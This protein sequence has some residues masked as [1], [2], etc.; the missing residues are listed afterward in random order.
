MQSSILGQKCVLTLGV[1]LPLVACEP[2]TNEYPTPDWN[3]VEPQFSEVDPSQ[4]SQTDVPQWPAPEASG[5]EEVT[6]AITVVA[7]TFD[8]GMKRYVGA[9]SL[10]TDS[11]DEHQAPIFDLY[12]GAILENVIIGSPAADGVH[13][14]G[15][16][17]LRNVWWEDV[18]EDAA[19]FRGQTDD[20]VLLI[21]GGGARLAD[22]KVF[23]HNGRGTF[24]L[25][26][27]HVESF[28]KVYRSC[29][30]CEEQV[31]RRVVIENI[32]AVTWDDSSAI[33]GINENYG[34]VAEFRGENFIFDAFDTTI[35]QRY[36]GNDM[37]LGPTTIG[38][39]PDGRHCLYDDSTV[40]LYEY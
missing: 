16:C 24:H 29:G 5:S 3:S 8:G 9:G 22:D 14:T 13:C 31:K 26:D 1:V 32:T 4:V 36:E 15:S 39:G 23:Q 6:H 35:C 34:D 20:D 27:L 11:Q 25:K 38:D 2:L 12:N 10:G 28:G 40:L 30:N 17:T 7:K 18:G 37:G 33:V 19:T 21:E